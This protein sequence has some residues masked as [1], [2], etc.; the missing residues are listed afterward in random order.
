MTRCAGLPACVLLLALQTHAKE[1]RFAIAADPKT[2]DSLQSAES[3]SEVIRYLTAGVLVRINR[4]TNEVEPELAESWQLKDGGRAIQFHLRAGLKFS[5]GKPLTAG[6]VARTLR[7]A[8]DPA[9]GSPTGDTFRSADGLPVVTVISP[10]DIAIRYKSP[11]PSIDRLF[12]ELGIG[13]AKPARLPASSGPFYVAEYTP[14]S[15]VRLVRNPNYWKRDSAGRQL[16]YLDSIRIDIQENHD[17]E[18]ARF[19]RGELQLILKLDPDQFERVNKEKPGAARDLGPSFDP[20]FMWFNQMPVKSL[21]EWKRQWF[22][23]AG[24]RHAVSAAIRR[25]DMARIVYRGHARSAAGPISPANSFWFNAALKIPSADPLKLFAA[26]GF[27]L[28]GGVLRDRAGRPVE[29]SLITNSGNRPRERM[30]ALLQSDLRKV[31][32]RVSVAT[33]DTGSVLDRITKSHDYEAALFGFSNVDED[34]MQQMNVWLSS[35]GL[36]PWWPNQKTPATAWEAR[37]DALELGQAAT[38]S[39]A[40]RKKAID[41]MQRI[42]VEQEP[43][44]HLVYPNALCAI[45]PLLKGVK[46]GVAPPGVLWN[47][48]WLRFD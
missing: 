15:F 14:G 16:P 36:H 10:R 9:E 23:S 38:A 26:E 45:S 13:P 34:P 27:A 28:R 30:A 1:L 5:D 22:G 21:P 20:E 42:A 44:L 39:R 25:D 4:S 2:F 11:K 37:M 32:I 29:F 6:D 24:F 31:G 7:R 12:D 3:G 18:L 35:G 19:L 8:L 47:I 43:I 40:E 33:L 41:E 48:E 46:P 17:I